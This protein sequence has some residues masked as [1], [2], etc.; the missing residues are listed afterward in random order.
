M[1]AAKVDE[2]SGRDGDKNRRSHKIEKQIGSSRFAFPPVGHGDGRP[3]RRHVDRVSDVEEYGIAQ[4]C[5]AKTVKYEWEHQHH[6][7][8]AA[9]QDEGHRVAHRKAA[10]A[11]VEKS[12]EAAARI[13]EKAGK[14]QQGCAGIERG[15]GN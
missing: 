4:C 8:D 9:R 6:I 1:E 13:G 10:P 12:S 3:D 11:A 7:D 15:S 14:R 5:L 2:Q